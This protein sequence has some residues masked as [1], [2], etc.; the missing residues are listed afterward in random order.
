[1]TEQTKWIKT[2]LSESINWQDVPPDLKGRVILKRWPADEHTAGGLIIPDQQDRRVMG[3]AW[4]WRAIG[5]AAK[6]LCP[7]DSVICPETCIGAGLHFPSDAEHDLSD[8]REIAAEDV[9]H[10]LPYAEAL[11]WFEAECDKVASQYAEEYPRI[12]LLAEEGQCPLALAMHQN[13][14]AKAQY[15]S[16]GMLASLKDLR[17]DIHRMAGEHAKRWIAEN[18]AKEVAAKDALA[19]ERAALV[20]SKEN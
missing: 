5:E 6:I 1:M 20:K 17:N 3:C 12:R 15:L 8:Y 7:G 16:A 18:D 19:K 4:V 13:L 10:V 2:P 9:Y 11:K 14:T